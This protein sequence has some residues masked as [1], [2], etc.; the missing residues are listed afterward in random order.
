MALNRHE[1]RDVTALL[2]WLLGISRTGHAAVTA[3]QARDAALHLAGSRRAEIDAAWT[4]RFDHS[5]AVRIRLAPDGDSLAWYRPES[6]DDER[7]WLVIGEDGDLA[8]EWSWHAEEY[9][10]DWLP[11]PLHRHRE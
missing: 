1:I 7:P 9:V 2:N 8:P 4:A 3:S 11:L 10:A 5:P 6:D